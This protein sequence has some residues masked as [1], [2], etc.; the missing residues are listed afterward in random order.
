MECSPSPVGLSTRR[1]RRVHSR[2]CWVA[3]YSSADP[4]V[5]IF[6]CWNP[7]QSTHQSRDSTNIPRVE[8][9]ERGGAENNSNVI[10]RI[11]GIALPWLPCG[12]ETCCSEMSRTSSSTVV[13]S[14]VP[15]ILFFLPKQKPNGSNLMA[16]NAREVTVEI[17]RN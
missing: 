15:L 5:V 4:I 3:L 16:M 13:P 11:K 2:C 17:S 9:N 1:N 10:T 8:S 6:A 14:S 7:L 12:C